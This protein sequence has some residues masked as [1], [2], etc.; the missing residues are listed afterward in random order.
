MPDFSENGI[1]FNLKVVLRPDTHS[2]DPSLQWAWGPPEEL[3]PGGQL[4][5][6][7]PGPSPTG[8]RGIGLQAERG[9]V[10]GRP[11]SS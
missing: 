3:Q 6:P 11:L 8:S 9:P 2:Q 4:P 10:T 5:G 7:S 1:E